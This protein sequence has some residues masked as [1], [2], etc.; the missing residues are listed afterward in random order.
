MYK[1]QSSTIAIPGGAS[2][3]LVDSSTMYVVGQQL[4]PDGFFGGHLTVVNL[5]TNKA[6]SLSLIHISPSRASGLR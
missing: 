2:N 3:A 6:S 4:M 5:S 1:R